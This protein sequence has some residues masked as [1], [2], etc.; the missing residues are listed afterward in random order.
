ML[1]IIDIS[2]ISIDI[3]RTMASILP[4]TY[5]WLTEYIIS[6]F[7]NSVLSFK[8][9]PSFISLL[10]NIKLVFPDPFPSVSYLMI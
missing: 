6:C 3:K 4:L 7:G 5:Y 1:T 10:Y 2:N 9:S 8:N